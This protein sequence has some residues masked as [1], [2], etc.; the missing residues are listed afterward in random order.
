MKLFAIA[1][2][3]TTVAFAVSVNIN[4][5]VDQA[6]PKALSHQFK[7]LSSFTADI[8][9]PDF[10]DYVR[11]EVS[12]RQ[13]EMTRLIAE[14]EPSFISEVPTSI[15]VPSVV[16]SGFDD[17]RG[18]DATLKRSANGAVIRMRRLLDQATP[19]TITAQTVN[20][21]YGQGAASESF[22][23]VSD[24]LHKLMTLESIKITKMSTT[25]GSVF[26]MGSKLKVAVKSGKTN[27]G[28]FYAPRDGH[29]IV[30]NPLT[31]QQANP[32]EE[33]FIMLNAASQAYC[34]FSGAD[35]YEHRTPK[36][37]KAYDYYGE[38][39]DQMHGYTY[40]R[41]TNPFQNSNRFELLVRKASGY[42]SIPARLANELASS[43][44]K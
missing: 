24:C 31:F 43:N 25:S 30:I 9:R 40:D 26:E 22:K 39:Y 36:Y 37:R 5:P 20:A 15:N 42:S 17:T 14:V 10:Q 19:S 11:A 27:N 18:R 34:D 4:I 21:V 33:A 8:D 6:P 41:R 44:F 13:S 32:M 23:L 38:P 7:Q 28:I 1:Q 35:Q 12:K 29:K 16:F 3:L 2:C